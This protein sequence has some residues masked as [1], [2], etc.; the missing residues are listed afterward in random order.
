MPRVRELDALRGLAALA[1][2]GFHFWPD[3]LF[4]GWAAVDLFFV[5]SGYLITAI[6]LEQ[7]SAPNFV[8]AFYA[9]RSLR[10]WP[11]YYL[12]LFGLIGV[13]SVLR[14]PAKLDA[15]PQFLTYT[16]HVQRYWGG[17]MPPFLGGVQ[18]TWTLALEEQ[19]YL[20]WPAL[21]CLVGPRGVVPLAVLLAVLA[22]ACRAIGLPPYL[23]VS[24]CDGFALGGLLAA[25]LSAR[26]RDAQRIQAFR[27]G[28]GL[29]IVAAAVYLIGGMAAY[30]GE[31]FFG[32]EHAGPLWS[33]P[34]FF[35]ICLLFAGVVGLVATSPGAPAWRVLRARSLV[36]VGQISYGLYLYHY[37]MWWL[38]QR[39]AERAGLGRPWWLALPVGVASVGVA[40]LSWRFVERPILALKDRFAYRP[41]DRAAS[42]LTPPHRPTLPAG[43]R[44]DHAAPRP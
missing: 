26:A 21:V 4:F 28:C 7:R 3:T 22:I 16:Q 2:M 29:A 8:A 12:T 18:H 27:W 15:L 11:I 6:I 19:Y 33:A 9:R 38:V 35:A 23:L 20:L 39:L 36:Y 42:A 14:L 40:A 37:V 24:R 32:G 5:L 31:R 13:A 1:V 25:L 43:S 17:S 41:G 44:F 10:I 34:T 30:G